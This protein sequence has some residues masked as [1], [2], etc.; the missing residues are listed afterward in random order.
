MLFSCGNDHPEKYSLPLEEDAAYAP[1]IE[2]GLNL[3]SFIVHKNEIK[4][5]E[6][7]ANILLKHHVPY[8]EI[9]RLAK[10]SVSVFY[11]RK[12]AAGKNYTI[13]CKKDSIEKAEYF[14]Y[15][16]NAIDYVIYDMRDSL[17]ITKGKREVTT[18]INTASGIIKSSLYQTLDDADVSPVLAIE[19]ANIFA[20][21]IDF[22]RLQKGDWFKVVY[23]EKFVAGKSIGIGK[24][25]AANFNHYNKD[26]FACRFI[27]DSIPDYFDAQ[28]N[29]LR[30]AFLKSPLKFGRLTSG[31]T[32]R[33][34]H[35]VQKR[36][37][38]HL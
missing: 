34:F 26:F 7:L 21:T 17:M 33:R 24:V 22:Y 23:E 20:W 30:R 18:E 14:I 37:K 29:S 10:E 9:D 5:N 31:F 35:P 25:M 13:L 3:D 15:E 38:P 12:I 6:F 8:A 2:Y 32:M 27:Q 11:V 4:P 16:A 1:T 28:A 19:M 36:N